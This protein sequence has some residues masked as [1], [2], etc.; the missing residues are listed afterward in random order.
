MLEDMYYESIKEQAETAAPSSK[1]YKILLAAGWSKKPK[2][3]PR[4]RPFPKGAENPQ[5]KK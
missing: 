4:G 2:G 5:A 3:K 1:F